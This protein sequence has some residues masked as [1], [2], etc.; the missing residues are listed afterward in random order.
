ME[1]VIVLHRSSPRVL[2]CTGVLLTVLSVLVASCS[3]EPGQPEQV[4]SPTA[5][6]PAIASTQGNS[7]LEVGTTMEQSTLRIPRGVA[8]PGGETAYVV[9]PQGFIERLNLENGEVLARTDFP[10]SPLTINRD[11][12]IGWTPAPGR[13]STRTRDGRAG[14]SRGARSTPRG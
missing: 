12:L 11:A 2:L 4:V 10:G 1:P 9:G 3:S 7:N 8:D 14:R 5:S 6:S 13:P